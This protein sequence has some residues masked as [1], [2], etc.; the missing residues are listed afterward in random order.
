[1]SPEQARG[2][3]VDTRSD[4]FSLGIVVYEMIT[5]EIPFKGETVSDVIAAI[6]QSEPKPLREHFGENHIP[7]EFENCMLRAL[8]KKRDERFQSV[9]EFSEHIRKCKQRIEFETEFK[10]VSDSGDLPEI[11]EIKD[12]NNFDS[13]QKTAILPQVSTQTNQTFF[14]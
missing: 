7:S 8:A 5:G 3:E 10:R 6:L 1:M 9:K 12:T 14:Q 4:I 11:S 13:E 2:L